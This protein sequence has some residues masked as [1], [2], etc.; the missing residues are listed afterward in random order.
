MDARTFP[1]GDSAI[2]ISFGDEIDL[3]TH[4]HV[5]RF[6]GHLAAYIERHG[7]PAVLEM[8]PAFTTVTVYYSPL[9][10]NY[11]QLEALLSQVLTEL[12]DATTQPPAKVVE[13]PVCYG[14]EYGPDLDNVSRHNH[15]SVEEVIQIH[16]SVDYLVYMIGFSP[17]FPYLGGMPE[18]IATPRLE[19]PRLSVPAGSVGI[20]GQQT[21]VYPTSSPGGW[22]L[23]GRTPAVLFQ[24]GQNPP[25]LLAAGDRVR[26]RPVTQEQYQE[27]QTNNEESFSL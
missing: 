16:T 14:G 17:G 21:G 12:P 6:T 7:H 2:V 27:Y 13:L 11:A 10:A 1:L 25:S 3:T 9:Q 19:T 8:V 18:Q 20:A 26:F 24:P 22:Q 15:L 5:M 23:I 4:R